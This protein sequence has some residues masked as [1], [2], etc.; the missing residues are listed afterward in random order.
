MTVG[1][2]LQLTMQL[3]QTVVRGTRSMP[4]MREFYTR[5]TMFG[6][7]QFLIRAQI[8]PQKFSLVTDLL[9]RMRGV[10][11]DSNDSG[12]P[13]PRSGMRCTMRVLF[14]GQEVDLDI[15]SLNSIVRVRDLV[16]VEVYNASTRMPQ[17]FKS[18]FL[19]STA[20]S[21]CGAIG[22]WTM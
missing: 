9:G 5:M 4:R 13:V 7:A 12:K 18:G 15:E 11:I 3:A 19:G 17:E 14:N 1:L 22:L 8:D 6:D 16:G 2:I 10:H 20:T 21:R